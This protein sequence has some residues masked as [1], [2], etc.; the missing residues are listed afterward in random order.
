MEVWANS[1]CTPRI[2]HYQL[3]PN[4]F[5]TQI[6]RWFVMDEKKIRLF[7]L[8]SKIARFHV[9]FRS[10]FHFSRLYKKKKYFFLRSF[11]GVRARSNRDYNRGRDRSQNS[12]E[13]HSQ[14][15]GCVRSAEQCEEFCLPSGQVS[16]RSRRRMIEVGRTAV[17]QL[18]P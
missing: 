11:L 2:G 12:I 7:D 4:G 13:Y 14:A 1:S 6:T 5:I 17:C 8:E 16:R 3:K 10:P 15:F 9:R 18:C